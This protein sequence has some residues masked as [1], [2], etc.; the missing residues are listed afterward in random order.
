MADIVQLKENGNFKYLKTHAKAVEGLEESTKTTINAVVPPMLNT[1][2]E[3]GTVLYN[4][5]SPVGESITYNFPAGVTLSSL[6]FGIL[7]VFDTADSAGVLTGRS[8]PKYWLK[9]LGTWTPIAFHLFDNSNALA[10]KF[11]K[12]NSNSI[13]GHKE[14][15]TGNRIQVRL[16]KLII[17]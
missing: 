17:L 12:I 15:D 9:E 14:N 6:K 5:N 10:L 3:K 2:L 8:I 4:G 7:F 11:F 1:F 13:Q 16:K